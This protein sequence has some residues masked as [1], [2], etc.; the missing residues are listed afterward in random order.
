MVRRPP[1]FTRTDPLFPYPW[2]FQS[3]YGRQTE[4]EPG[5]VV[6]GPLIATL[7]CRAFVRANPGKAVESVSYRGLRPLIAPNAFEVAGRIESHGAASLWARQD[8]TLAHQAT[9]QFGE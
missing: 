4:G 3:P 1:G 5:L 6:H 9:I 2:L 8:D 7:V